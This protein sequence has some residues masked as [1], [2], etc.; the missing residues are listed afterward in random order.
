MKPFDCLLKSE[1]KKAEKVAN[2]YYNRNDC[3][4]TACSWSAT[5]QKYDGSF[6]TSWIEVK[7]EI[8]FDYKE[9]AD[10]DVIVN[11]FLPDRRRSFVGVKTW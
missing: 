9:R 4:V 1:I 10:H 11:C 5:D 8:C 2:E 3:K 7:C 6:E